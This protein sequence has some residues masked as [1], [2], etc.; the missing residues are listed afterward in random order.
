MWLWI[1]NIWKP[2]TSTSVV[3]NFN[4]FK[5]VSQAVAESPYKFEGE[6]ALTEEK[7]NTVMAKITESTAGNWNG[8]YILIV[9]CGLLS[10]LS[11]YVTALTSGN[12]NK[13]AEEIN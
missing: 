13:Q 11:F 7:Y 12:K 4:E 6:G 2:D 3:S 9:L 8:Y 1:S 10:F 5:T